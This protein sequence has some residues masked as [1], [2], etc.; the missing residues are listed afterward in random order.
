LS[1][2]IRTE[3]IT[4][5]RV[6]SEYETAQKL[7]VN[8]DVRKDLYEA[9]QNFDMNSLKDFHNSHISNGNRVLMV[10]GSKEDLDLEVLKSYGEIKHLTLEDIFGY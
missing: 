6:L 1:K 2:K 7:G 4:K 9:I 8:Y 3:R 10:L 5:S